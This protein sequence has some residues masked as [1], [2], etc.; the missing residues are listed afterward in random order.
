MSQGAWSIW[1]TAF[2][3]RKNHLYGLLEET[4]I[5]LS[6]LLKEGGQDPFSYSIFSSFYP[7]TIATFTIKYIQSKYLLSSDLPSFS[8]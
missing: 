5:H 2:E 4:T 8:A 1:S 7:K 3:E 6:E